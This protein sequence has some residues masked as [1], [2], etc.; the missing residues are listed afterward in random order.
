MTKT[1]PSLRLTTAV[2][3]FV[4]YSQPSD[5]RIHARW[6]AVRSDQ[7]YPFFLP[8]YDGDG[9]IFPDLEPSH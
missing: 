6:F 3:D 7:T 9:S 8:M 1:Q 2:T 5:A 4:D